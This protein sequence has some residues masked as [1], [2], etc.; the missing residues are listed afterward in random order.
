[1]D[2]AA[3]GARVARP[4]ARGAHVARPAARTHRRVALHRRSALPLCVALAVGVVAVS[5]APAPAAAEERDRVRRRLAEGRKLYEEQE[6]RAAIRTLAPVGR[7]TTATRAQRLEALELL[8]LC[9]FILGDE[10]QAREAFEDLLA[11]DPGYSLREASDSPKIRKFFERVKK[12]YIPDYEPTAR[13]SLEHAAPDSA[14]AGRRLELVVEVSKGA[15]LVKEVN[16]RWR[17][18]GVLQYERTSM[19]AQGEARWRARF[20]PPSDEAGYALE[21]FIEAEDIAGAQLARI[22]GPETPLALS[23]SGAPDASPA[24]YRRWYVWVGAGAVVLGTAAVIVVTS[25]DSAPSGSL[26]TVDLG[27]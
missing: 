26:G 19:N 2:R 23:L 21:Y 12:A 18:R 11:I 7:D 22:A 9:S 24:W 27:H 14:V 25:G 13:V 17:R 3:L 5:A 16:L 1:M 20:T 8:G 10:A 15:E 6:Y 4:D